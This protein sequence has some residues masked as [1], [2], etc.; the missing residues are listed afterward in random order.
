MA[1]RILIIDD[2]ESMRKLLVKSVLGWMGESA[3]IEEAGDG[4]EALVILKR[5]YPDIVITDIC[6]PRMDGLE[7]IGRAAKTG[8]SMKF[9]VISGYDEFEY[10]KKAISLGVT[11]Y[12][13]K[14]FLPEELEAVLK[15]VMSELDRQ[16]QLLINM[17]QLHEKITSQNCRA[18]E[19]L[20]KELL[21]GKRREVPE[22][23]PEMEVF[24]FH[25]ACYAIVLLHIQFHQ[26][27][28]VWDLGRQEEIEKFLDLLSGGYFGPEIRV[29]GISLVKNQLI[30]IWCGSSEDRDIFGRCIK[31]GLA[32]LKSSLKKYY[33][34]QI[35]GAAGEIVSSW[36]GLHA[37]YQ[38]A[39]SLW[40]KAARPQS[41]LFYNEEKNVQNAL[42]EAAGRITGLKNRLEM[43]VKM[44]D[45]ALAG[46]LLDQ[47]MKCYASLSG[48]E[49]GYI[50][51]SIGE[52]IYR[53]ADEF[54]RTSDSG[55]ASDISESEQQIRR[56]LEVGNL[57]EI[58]EAL[59]EFIEECC[60][61][62]VDSRE[63]KH[64]GQMVKKVKA[65]VEHNLEDENLNL[66]KVASM[67]FFS[68][69]YIRQAFR[70]KTGERFSDYVIRKRM[71]RAGKLLGDPALSVRDVAQ[72]CG[73]GNQR[74]FA[75]S[76]RKFY[77]CTPTE[78]RETLKRS[79]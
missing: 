23:G 39:C 77:G 64:A 7:L 69:N 22:N 63:E 33:S 61:I 20:L 72:A 17:E 55:R 24:D 46:E 49:A 43:S 26:A 34:I 66:D 1:Y 59:E 3:L 4:E 57:T 68:P 30:L 37:S 14:P 32:H 76:F 47:L 38:T 51:V 11:D 45:A 36:T 41:F 48:R 67:L 44:G 50:S 13:L 35:W 73:Y 18:R 28:G 78:Y 12:L 52:F 58:K 8:I 56:S 9:V 25:A 70:R 71:E 21:L 65:C 16:R 53:V 5:F 29:Y 27:A 74:Y 19:Y 42:P 10:A 62:A 60:S 2:E 54:V 75:S 79:L 15:K 6:M 31:Q 40:N